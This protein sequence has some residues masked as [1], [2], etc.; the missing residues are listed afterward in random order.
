MRSWGNPD[1]SFKP[2]ANG[3]TMVM[4]KG[5]GIGAFKDLLS[6]AANHIDF[7]KLGFGTL[8]ITP[9]EVTRQK[10]AMAKEYGVHLYPGGTFFEVAYLE[11]KNNAYLQW[12]KVLGFEWVE[13]SSGIVDYDQSERQ[14]LIQSAIKE[15]FHVITEI[16]KKQAG[17]TTELSSLV[18]QFSKDLDAGASY[19]IVEGRETGENIG[20]YNKQGEVDTSYVKQ[21][22][23]MIDNNKCIWETPKK[24]QQV[25]L[26]ELAGCNVNLGNIAPADA[27]SVEA[28]RQG[29]R[30]D[31][32]TLWRDYT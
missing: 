32:L 5:L 9:E 13:I 23:Q 28:L 16:G 19:V 26:M 20:I 24:G 25:T 14:S 7:I 12:L 15:Q 17:S 4:D 6:L 8:A 1:R 3:I 22:L 11:K 21:V 18:H 2:R 31:T 29:L 27:L 30:A 10:L